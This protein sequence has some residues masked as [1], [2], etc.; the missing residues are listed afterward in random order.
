MHN[1]YTRFRVP[2][3][4]ALRRSP[5]I[6]TY[7]TDPTKTEPQSNA[8]WF[9]Q[10]NAEKNIYPDARWLQIN[11]HVDRFALVFS[12]RAFVSVPSVSKKGLEK[13]RQLLV[14]CERRPCLAIFAVTNWWKSSCITSVRLGFWSRMRKTW[15][16]LFIMNPQQLDKV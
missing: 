12:R 14:H 13:N 4:L 7:A 15:L 9:R 6:Y 8:S 1:I 2:E 3:T 11:W 5:H 10:S 16:D